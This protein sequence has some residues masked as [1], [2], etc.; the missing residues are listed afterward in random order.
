MN[1]AK[2]NNTDYIFEREKIYQLSVD[3]VVGREVMI[4]ADACE[5]S[6]FSF[7]ISV[8]FVKSLFAFDIGTSL[9]LRVYG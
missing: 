6:S 9:A 5:Y 3:I 4:V 7:R 8:G 1:D 2:K